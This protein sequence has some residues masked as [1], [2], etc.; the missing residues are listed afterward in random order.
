VC[1]DQYGRFADHPELTAA[2]RHGQL[3]LGPM[4]RDELVAAIEQPA[5]AAELELDAGLTEV[6]L[7]DLG[8]ADQRGLPGRGPAVARAGSA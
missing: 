8:V 4:T 5:Q 7:S 2:L 3:M 6:L 1:T